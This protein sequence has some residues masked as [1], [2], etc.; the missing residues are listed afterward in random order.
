MKP[1]EYAL[2][3]QVEGMMAIIGTKWKPAI[4]FVLV[5]RGPLRF[6]ALRRA[7]PGISQKVLTQRLRELERDGLVERRHYPEIPPRVEYSVTK[8]GQEL[9][10][11][12]KAVCDWGVRNMTKIAAANRHYDG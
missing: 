10:P 1:A 3:Q 8:L 11:L 9:D 6:V 4:M 2:V 7:I 12:Y 5:H